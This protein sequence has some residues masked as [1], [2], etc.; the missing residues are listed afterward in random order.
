VSF[1]NNFLHCWRPED[2]AIWIREQ[3]P[4]SI[5][6][7]PTRFDRFHDLIEQLPSHC[8]CAGKEHV[9]VLVGMRAMESSVRRLQT[10]EGKAKFKGV[11]WCRA[12]IPNTRVFWPLYDWTD[13]DVWTAIA[14]HDWPY[15]RIYDLMS[16]CSTSRSTTGWPRPSGTTAPAASTRSPA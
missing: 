10:T 15:N 16:W 3:D 13:R 14:N 2:R 7:N 5:K 8:D 11:N 4:L 12:P 9:A 6:T 1:A